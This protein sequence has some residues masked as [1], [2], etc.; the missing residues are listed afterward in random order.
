ML[1]PATPVLI[2][3]DEDDV[4]TLL[5]HVLTGAGYAVV[6]AASAAAALA[7][8]ES[9]PRPAA[10]LVDLMMP[11]IDGWALVARLRAD[12]RWASL[13]VIVCTAVDPSDA[14]LDD[15]G[16]V[17]AVLHKPFAPDDL[18]SLVRRHAA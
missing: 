5:G 7:F 12:P 2:V 15:I 17:A 4:R 10:L 3:D 18:V 13:P 1:R 16:P 9:G 6:S 8:L 11:E 14:R